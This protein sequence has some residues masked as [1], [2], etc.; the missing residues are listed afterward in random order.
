[1]APVPFRNR[2]ETHPSG[3]AAYLRFVPEERGSGVRGAL[4]L[5]NARAEPVDFAF[6]RTD[7]A[8]S[9]LWRA[10]EARR[11]AVANLAAVLFQACPQ[12]PD[13]L[14]AL[15]SEVDPRVFTED[16]QVEAPACRVD[17]SGAAAYTTGETVEP[18][19]GLAHLFWLGPPPG[20]GSPA[21]RVLEALHEK[22]LLLEPFERAAVGLSEA[23]DA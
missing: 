16:L 13:V 18:L 6:S 1:M 5:V 8:T 21:R 11:S 3:L 4:F 9:F 2:R 14:L 17:P 7:V 22:R 20:D 10:G 23:F 19:A 12:S 15:A